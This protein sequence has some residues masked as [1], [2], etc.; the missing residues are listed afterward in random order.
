MATATTTAPGTTTAR[1]R[2]RS[3]SRSG[4]LR[5]TFKMT[6]HKAR[7]LSTGEIE[8]IRSGDETWLMTPVAA[9]AWGEELIATADRALKAGTKKPTK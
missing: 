1:K 5:S 3:R 2:S 9:R 6:G 8:C 7:V 4:G